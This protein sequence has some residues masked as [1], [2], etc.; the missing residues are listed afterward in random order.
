MRNIHDDHSEEGG[1]HAQQ[2]QAVE[3][4]RGT[5]V[6]QQVLREVAGLS[7]H[8]ILYLTPDTFGWEEG[9]PWTLVSA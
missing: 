2:H 1:G 8:N 9:G 3:G 7:L 6:E 4:G 5:V